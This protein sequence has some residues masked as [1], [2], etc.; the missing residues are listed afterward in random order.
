MW[1]GDVAARRSTWMSLIRFFS[2]L[3]VVVAV[4]V[5]AAEPQVYRNREFG[6]IV[7]VPKGALLCST[8]AGQHDHGPIF[9]LGSSD[10]KGCD[11]S[12]RHRAIVIFAGYNA[13]DVTRKLQ[14]FLRWECNGSCG[15]APAGLR[16]AELPSAAAR[17]NRSGGWMDIIVVTQA[18]KSDPAS[19]PPVPSINYDLRLHT[20]ARNLDEDLR[21]FRTVLRSI[22]LSPAQ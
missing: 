2:F 9:L 20:R 11:D 21:T 17:V 19:D 22:R 6:I 14:D 3:V 15:V 18:G 4:T 16:V 7:P 1:H 13:A 8:P 5:A 10:A 12:E